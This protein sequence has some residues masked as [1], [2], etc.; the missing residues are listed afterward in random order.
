VYNTEKCLGAGCSERDVHFLELVK[1]SQYTGSCDSPEDV[2]SCSLHQGHESFIL[3][4]LCEAVQGTLVLNSTSGGHHHAPSDGV[5]GIGHQ[6]SCDS[7]CP[8]KKEGNT[9]SGIFTEQERLEC[10]IKTEV[11]A[12]VDKDTNSRDGEASVQTLDTIRLESLHVDINETIE[13]TSSSLG[14]VVIGKPGSGVVQGVYEEKGQ[15]SSSSTRSDVGGEFTLGRGVLGGGEDCLNA[16]LEGEV[17]SLSGEVTK[18]I[19]QVTTPQWVDTLC[20]KDTSEAVN[21]SVIRL[22]QTTLLDHLILV[23]DEKLDSLDGSGGSLGDSSSYT[24]QQE[25]LHKT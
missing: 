5:D 7:Y 12:T 18:D 16:V 3:D 25:I 8:P 15:S 23:L 19:G 2:S 14:L 4:N 24:S 1:S 13:L 17:K 22:V 9:N 11:H 10:I 6:S 20:G 21:D